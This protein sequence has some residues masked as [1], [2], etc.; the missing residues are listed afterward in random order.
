V[1]ISGTFVAISKGT[2]LETLSHFSINTYANNA[3]RTL[4]TQGGTLADARTDIL[5]MVGVAIVGLI[6]SRFLFRATQEGK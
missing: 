5:V 6:I 4:I 2:L 1:M 3:F